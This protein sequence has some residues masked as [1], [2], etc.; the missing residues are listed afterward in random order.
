MTDYEMRAR[1]LEGNWHWRDSGY[2]SIPSDIRLEQFPVLA[3][4]GKTN[5]RDR[6]WWFETM[7]EESRKLREVDEW[8]Q[9]SYS[10]SWNPSLMRNLICLHG[11]FAERFFYFLMRD[12]LHETYAGDL[13]QLRDLAEL[14][15]RLDRIAP[16]SAYTWQEKW[17]DPIRRA[18]NH[19]AH[20]DQELQR[21]ARGL[22]NTIAYQRLMK[23]SLV[24]ALQEGDAI[25]RL[26]KWY[27]DRNV[28]QYCPFCGFQFA[29][30]DMNIWSYF[31]SDGSDFCCL[32]CPLDSPSKDELKELIP[33][34]VSKCGFIPNANA[35]P[36]LYAFSS[37]IAYE[38]RLEA[39][40]VY[41][42]MGGIGHVSS[43]FGSWFK[44]LAETGVL[45]DRMQETARGYRCIAKDGHECR[46]LDEMMIDDWLSD[47]EIAHE[48]EPCYPMHPTLNP[49]ERRKADWKVGDAWVEYF[50]LAGDS[51]Y[52]RKSQDKLHLASVCDLKIVAIYPKDLKQGSNRLAEIFLD[53]S[54]SE[55]LEQRKQIK[56]NGDSSPPLQN[57]EYCSHV[58]ET[59]E[60]K[61]ETLIDV[62]GINRC[63]SSDIENRIN[64]YA[65]VHGLLDRT[66]VGLIHCD[67]KL[68][69][70][71][72][73][74]SITWEDFRDLPHARSVVVAAE[75]IGKRRDD[76][77]VESLI[78]ALAD[79]DPNVRC[80][81]AEAFGE[82]RD[83]GAIE[84]LV[85][86]LEDEL[87][88]VQKAAAGSLE[89]IGG[90]GTS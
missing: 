34:F 73:T 50:G 40:H 42:K 63:T 18:S 59:Y 2:G 53:S 28:R 76:R 48:K 45:P 5:V 87:G 75:G 49:H 14:F 54:T 86:A 52:D 22:I 7:D 83:A 69:S 11:V 74:D 12:K 72:W 38:N 81:G 66:I 6:E 17:V 4:S 1:R 13:G 82:I 37:R 70:I 20:E 46:S 35:H 62:L 57:P 89:K 32:T 30:I 26:E 21:I 55:D 23:R 44:A 64:R 39:F 68:E 33:P 79:K 60:I 36:L 85:A 78:A 71:F 43:Q 84:P 58:L 56:M 24:D 88:Y 51:E 16:W 15:A 61:N 27:K 25:L 41:C 67:E 29:V 31:Q 65:I 19:G 90:A 9:R 77:S 3:S 80:A 47:N 10:L 8:I